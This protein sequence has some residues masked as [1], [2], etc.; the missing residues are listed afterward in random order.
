[1]AEEAGL[2]PIEVVGWNKEAW[3]DPSALA[4][5]GTKASG[6]YRTTLLSPF[7]SLIWE[8]SRTERVF[9]FTHRLEA[10]VPKAKR[11][12]GYYAMPLLH[13]GQLVGRV[14]PAKDGKTLIAR[15]TSLDS[16]SSVEPMACALT[17][18]AAWVGC[19]DVRVEAVKPEKFTNALH[20]ALTGR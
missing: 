19:D 2:I 11:V 14:D 1:I 18:A 4:A 13:R 10:Y 17:E 16:A 5:L 20:A 12:H 3:A 15:Q 9:G 7:D 8:R 6:R